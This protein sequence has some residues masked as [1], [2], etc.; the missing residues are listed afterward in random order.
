[1]STPQTRLRLA[2]AR[3]RAMYNPQIM[4]SSTGTLAGTLTPLVL[5]EKS[6]I[7]ALW[8][9][10]SVGIKLA[11][12]IRGEKL[13]SSDVARSLRLRALVLELVRSG[14]LLCPTSDQEDEYEAERL[15]SEV[16]AEFSRLSQGVRMNHR[17][18]VQDAQIHRAM[19]AFLSGSGEISLP[20]R[21]YFHDDP[22][23]T[24]EASKSRKFIVCV[25]TPEGSPIIEM[26]RR[27]KEANLHEAEALRRQLKAKRQTYE[28]QLELE[29]KS[30]GNGMAYVL[31][32]FHRNVIARE[33]DF[34][35]A[36]AASGFL[37]YVR[38]WGNR[39]GDVRAL[40]GFMVS[41][42]VTSLPILRISSQLHA[43][44]V[45]GNDAVQ[46]GDADDIKLLSVAIP[47]VHFVLTDKKM[48]NRIKRLGIDLAWKTKVFSMSTID[49]LF[50]ELEKLRSQP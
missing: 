30:F 10:T 7:P 15:D 47:L 23:R 38:W 39:G 49:A 13:S 50:A 34:E 24:I 46:S 32:N 35:N 33:L 19:G 45:T 28:A 43:D 5:S 21:I 31:R 41:E 48:E 14:E 4:V 16:F 40:H 22:V 12:I 2:Q 1:V 25:T 44:L 11:K 17:I 42:Y 27:V 26:R 36:M 9:D 37:E 3:S 8:L 29:L 20:W 6:P 18:A